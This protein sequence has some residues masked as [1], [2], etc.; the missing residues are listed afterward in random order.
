MKS[1][2]CEDSGLD[3]DEATDI[4][5]T[6]ENYVVDNDFEEEIAVEEVAR[7]IVT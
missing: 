2:C 3:K 7:G 4:I 5:E 6:A 1:S